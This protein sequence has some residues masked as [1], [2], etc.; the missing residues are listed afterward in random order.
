MQILEEPSLQA[1]LLGLPALPTSLPSRIMV[2]VVVVVVVVVAVA[3]VV[4]VVG[5]VAV[6]VV[7]V[8]VVV[9]NMPLGKM[10]TLSPKQQ[11]SIHQ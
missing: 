10:S 9:T 1:N 11:V 4:V 3:V 7:V 5:V 6:V 8:V 2:V